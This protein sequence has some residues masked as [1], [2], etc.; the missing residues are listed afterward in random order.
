MYIP[1]HFRISDRSVLFDF[2]AKNNFGIL[3]TID[4]ATPIATHLPFLFEPERGEHGVLI[5]HIAK[6]NSQWKTFSPDRAALIIFQGP[7]AY[8]SPSWYQEHPSVPTWDYATVYAY[9]IPQLIDNEQATHK[10][11]EGLVD[12]HEAAFEHPWRMALPDDYY[13]QQTKAVV[14]FEIEIVRLEGKFKM[15]QNRSAAD[16]SGVI[17]ALDQSSDDNSIEV[18]RFIEKANQ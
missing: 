1:D 11:L 18:A 13:R 14:A 7:H 6:A 15:S 12:K 2:I 17:A 4:Q 9:G 5:G 10:L 16:R 3:V 8:I